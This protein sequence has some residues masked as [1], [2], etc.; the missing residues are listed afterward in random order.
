MADSLRLWYKKSTLVVLPTY[1]DE[2]LPRV[3]LEAQA[4]G[5][6]PIT[7]NS[8]GVSEAILNNQTGFYSKKGDLT[9]LRKTVA[10]LITDEN[11][12]AQ[13]ANNGR[14]FVSKNFSLNALAERH[15][16]TYLRLIR[17]ATNCF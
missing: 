1:H 15:E 17:S 7:Y 2:G 4:M 14:K 10:M 16:R 13:I 5:I 9:F 3:L 8:G 12:R 11:K 6:P